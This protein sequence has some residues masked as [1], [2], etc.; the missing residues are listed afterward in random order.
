MV[1]TSI[2]QGT[3]GQQLTLIEEYKHTASA[4]PLLMLLKTEERSLC[5][6]QLSHHRSGGGSHNNTVKASIMALLHT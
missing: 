6:I 3:V 2:M 4:Q 1:D 5:R